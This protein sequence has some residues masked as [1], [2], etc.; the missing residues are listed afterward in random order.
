MN[1]P[2]HLILIHLAVLCTLMV[3][4]W[5]FLG[6]WR[7]RGHVD[8]LWALAIGIQAGVFAML[9]DGWLPRRIAVACLAL[10]WAGRLSYHLYQ[11]L[12][13]DG[14]DGRYLAM[15]KA[16]GDRSSQFFFAFFQLQAVA[17]WV[18]AI[19]FAALAQSAE[20]AWS[21]WELL[22]LGLWL[23]SLAGNSIADRQLDRWR[24]NPANRGRTCRAGMWAWSRHPN[25]F[26]EWLLWCAYPI[27]A[28]GTP[29]LWL[30]IA[31]AGLMFVM[32]TKVSGIPFT[33]QQ[34]IRS[35]GQDYLDYQKT[36]SAF[37]P[38]PPRHVTDHS[39]R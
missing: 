36:T 3:L 13:R 16:A 11:R 8:L 9:S 38:L 34:A 33:E 39:S 18:F 15:E 17:A 35:R 25:Y 7:R 30:L 28:I 27:A 10:L 20:Q 5:H 4:A 1:L 32:V 37:L 26:F 12:G 31:I 19:P 21:Q 24:R 22:G 14:E 23:L 6:K 2:A 29:N